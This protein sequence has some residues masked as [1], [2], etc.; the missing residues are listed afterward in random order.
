LISDPRSGRIGARW[1]RGSPRCAQADH[2]ARPSGQTRHDWQWL[3]CHLRS[4]PEWDS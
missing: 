3:L 4:R 1:D 2:E